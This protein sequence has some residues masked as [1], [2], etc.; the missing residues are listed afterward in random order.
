MSGLSSFEEKVGL[1]NKHSTHK[2]LAPTRNADNNE[3]LCPFLD[4][5]KNGGQYDSQ[6]EVINKHN[7]NDFCLT[8][9]KQIRKV[10]MDHQKEYLAPH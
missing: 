10:R 2:D 3:D 9:E 8:I 5:P 1:N 4:N 7:E 6:L